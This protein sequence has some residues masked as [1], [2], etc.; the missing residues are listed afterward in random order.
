M[1][2]R[3]GVRWFADG[4]RRESGRCGRVGTA[5][6]GVASV[7]VMVGDGGAGGVRGGGNAESTSSELLVIGS[8]NTV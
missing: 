8:D 6:P 3:G 4:R 2:G 5:E 1:P 7:R